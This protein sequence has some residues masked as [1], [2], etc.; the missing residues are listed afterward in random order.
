MTKFVTCW[1]N[2]RTYKL[3]LFLDQL[4]DC[5][6]KLR[7][8]WINIRIV[9]LILVLVEQIL[10]LVGL[11]IKMVAFWVCWINFGICWTNCR[12]C[13][14]GYLACWINVGFF[15][16]YCFGLTLGLVGL[17]F[18]LMG[19]LLWLVWLLFD[20][21]GFFCFNQSI[22]QSLNHAITQ[23]LTYLSSLKPNNKNYFV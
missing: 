6:L 14:T 10:R 13:W 1:T 16:S 4:C 3:D 21:H 12:V 17:I 8:C 23:S 18:R 15:G 19:P 2:C 20:L 5:W 22:T 11:I 9:G 7:A